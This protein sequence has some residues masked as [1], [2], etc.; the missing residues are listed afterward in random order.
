[1]NMMTVA[2][3]FGIWGGPNGDQSCFGPGRGRRFPIPTPEVEP[4]RTFEDIQQF[5]SDLKTKAKLVKVIKS[6]NGRRTSAV[7][8]EFT[9]G[10]KNHY[11]V[12]IAADGTFTA[13]SK[14]GKISITFQH[15]TAVYGAPK[16]LVY[17]NTEDSDQNFNQMP[18]GLGVEDLVGKLHDLIKGAP[19]AGTSAGKKK[20]TI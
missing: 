13:S 1:M 2:P 17:K 5:V 8:A 20:P 12:K 7:E 16:K 14:N 15:D 4:S 6:G 3:K 11:N 18:N 19:K 10:S 9:F